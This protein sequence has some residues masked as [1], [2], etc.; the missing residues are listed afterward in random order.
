[1]IVPLALTT[2]RTTSTARAGVRAVYTIP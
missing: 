2:A 1:L